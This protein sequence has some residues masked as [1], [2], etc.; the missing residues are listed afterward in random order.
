MTLH[1]P[2]ASARS[3]S[4]RS[5][6]LATALAAVFIAT[7]AALPV[8]AASAAPANLSQGKPATASS[9]EN[10]DYTPASAAFDGDPGT[11]WASQWSDPQWIQVDLGARAS[12]D[13]VDL[14]WEGA[15]A[16]SYEIQVSDSGTG[17][18]T[19]IYSTTSGPGGVESLDVEGAGRYVR[20]LGTERANGYGYSLWEFA[21]FGT[22]GDGTT[23]PDPDPEPGGPVDAGH[24]NQPGP[25]TQPSVVRVTGGHG[26][27]DLSVDGKPYTVK[28]FTWGPSF[29]EAGEY[30]DDFTAMGANTTRTWGTGADTVQLLDVAAQYGVRVINGFWL[31]PG[32][33]PGSGGCIDYTTDAN[34]K[35]TTK[36]DILNWVN[37]YKSHPATLMWN[38][39]NESLLGLQNCYSGD[40]L[41]AQRTAYASYVNEV[42]LAIK[43]I[44]PNHPVTSTDAWTGAWPYYRANTPALDL[45]SVNSY[46]DVCN[47]EQTWV[48]GGYDKPYIVTEG[49]AA[50]EWEVPD[51]A[52]GVPDEPTDLEKGEAYVDS[53]RCLREHDGVALGAT[54]FH[55]GL[56]GDFGGVWFNVIPGGNKR[57]GY[58]TVADMWNGSAADGNTPPR[59][60]G[61]DIPGSS[62]ITAGEP[63]TVTLDVT[64]PDGDPLNYVTFV[65]SKYID[66]AGGVQ[67]V[68]HQRAGNR[69]TITAPQKLG[70]WK[71]YVYVEDGQGNVGVETRSFRVVAPA[72]D[73]TNV[74]LGKP[75]TASSFQ[76]WGDDYTPGRAFDGEQSTRW[77]SEWAPT[78]WVQVDLG[79]P[80]A[81]DRI[82]LI[83]ESAFAKSYEVQTS[84]DGTNWSTIQT[85]T[86][87]D[88]GIDDVQ[89]AGNARY[90]RL[91]LTERGTDWG[92]S[93]YEVGIY[94]TN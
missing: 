74:A 31:L 19:T 71:A 5:R 14:S 92:F 9:V 36:A 44:D 53:W 24:P 72:I 69:I 7:T 28:G 43:Q 85:V 75:A 58:Y 12:I 49:G 26:D 70:V 10:A 8:T 55:F 87:G 33:G 16:R 88:G 64:D 90:V 56:E 89:A 3:R 59:I 82:Q 93:L 29:G 35:D 13:R 34:Y 23:G 40:Q 4:G 37:T 45:L 73:G 62:A 54:F 21:V 42:A 84:N 57:L 86:G 22:T 48:D 15:Y 52:N 1:T 11:R 30:M 63:F 77:S 60:T 20:L 79:Q 78:G 61:M 65:N 46:G 17:G 94:R 27:W 76:V 39:G 38:V 81:F 25:F 83:W 51:D 80:T 67:F 68:E 50:G 91:N 2:T 6:I 18:W 41:E 47:I 32:G 66:G